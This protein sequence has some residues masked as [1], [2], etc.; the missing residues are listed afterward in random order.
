M[1]DKQKRSVGRNSPPVDRQFGR[2]QKRGKGRPSGALGLKTIVK[3]F[4]CE[5]HLASQH[6][7]DLQ[8]TTVELLLQNMSVLALGGD[9][10]ASKWLDQ[11]I[12]RFM[13]EPVEG[14]GYLVV[15]E[16]L[17]VKEWIERETKLN[18]IRT[19]PRLKDQN[20]Q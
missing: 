1:T 6:G 15:P 16:P 10:R 18:L 5:R 19:D 20:S 11:Y 9:T 17:P 8:L 14:G 2:G 7:K 12:A 13:P 4:A 3:K